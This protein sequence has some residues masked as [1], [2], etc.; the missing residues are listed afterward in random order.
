[1]GFT[2]NFKN[3]TNF[4]AGENVGDATKPFENEFLV[5]YGDPFVRKISKNSLISQVHM[6][7]TYGYNIYS[8]IAG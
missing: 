6:A 8:D 1:L 5:N 7:T 4:A 3:I 2:S